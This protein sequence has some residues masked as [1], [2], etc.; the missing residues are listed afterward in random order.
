MEKR[1]IGVFSVIPQKNDTQIKIDHIDNVTVEDDQ[2]RINDEIT[3][4]FDID[5]ERHVF[6][7]I[8]KC[9]ITDS[10]LSQNKKLP[11]YYINII[12]ERSIRKFLL[13]RINVI[14]EIMSDIKSQDDLFNSIHYGM[15]EISIDAYKENALLETTENINTDFEDLI[16]FIKSDD[17]MSITNELIDQVSDDLKKEFE[18]MWGDNEIPTK[19]ISLKNYK[20]D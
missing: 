16:T 1:V 17:M 8:N 6:G 19:V 3:K 14:F 10:F 9:H 7:E 20:I 12:Q 5:I 2:Q 11:V 4:R 13:Y 15:Y 18:K